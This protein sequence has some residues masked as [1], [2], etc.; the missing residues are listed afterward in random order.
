MADL[1]LVKSEQFGAIQCDFYQADNNFWMTREQIGAALEYSNPQKAIDNLHTRHA[2][3]LSK[4][5]VTLKLRATDGKLYDTVVYSAKGIYEI[6]RW[7]QQPKAD[8]FYDWVYD[9][10][11]GIR[12]G[13]LTAKT[14]AAA[15]WLAMSEEDRAIA[16]FESRKQLKQLT[17]KA[18]MFDTF[19][20]AENSQDMNTVAKVLGIGRNKL[21]AKLR[22]EKIL[23][24]NNT[25]YQDYLDR[26]YFKVIEKTIE[27]GGKVIV[28]PQTYVTAKGVEYLANLLK[29][30]TA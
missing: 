8:A 12:T 27:M 29:K 6:C 1:Q 2:D 11:E 16:Y 22:E 19:M 17:P 18:E 23:R 4:L 26:G 28:K 15:D 21:F 30:Q 9:L 5:S 25:P 24:H 10:L 3:R 7:S 13:R 14:T 20:Q